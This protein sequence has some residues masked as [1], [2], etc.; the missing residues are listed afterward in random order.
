MKYKTKSIIVSTDV[1]DKVENVLIKGIEKPYTWAIEVLKKAKVNG[2]HKRIEDTFEKRESEKKN[3]IKALKISSCR[4][5]L[6]EYYKRF[7]QAVL[8][9]LSVGCELPDKYL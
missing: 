1:G 9:T 7:D 3:R 5:N 8:S 2:N 4:F 6:E